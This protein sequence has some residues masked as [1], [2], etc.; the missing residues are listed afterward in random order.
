MVHILRNCQT[1]FQSLCTTSH[2]RGTWARTLTSSP[3]P[4]LES[5][6]Q[7]KLNN[8]SSFLR[9]R[10]QEYSEN[11]PFQA[12]REEVRSG[13]SSSWQPLKSLYTLCTRILGRASLAAAVYSPWVMFTLSCFLVYKEHH[14][15]TFNCIPHVDKA[16]SVQM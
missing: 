9:T 13:L 8:I 14:T 2:P 15:G 16:H 7:L 3:T 4:V 6:V 12:P 5:F 1:P 11:I 10:F